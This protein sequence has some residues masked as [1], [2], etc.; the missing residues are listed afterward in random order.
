MNTYRWRYKLTAND[1]DPN[2]LCA[3]SDGKHKA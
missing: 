3:P 2:R 1:K